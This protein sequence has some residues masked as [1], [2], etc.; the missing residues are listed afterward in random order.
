MEVKRTNVLFICHVISI[1]YER[2]RGNID[3]QK[4]LSW[5]KAKER[6]TTWNA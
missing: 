3:S 6:E 4:Y 5:N 2:V 1:T